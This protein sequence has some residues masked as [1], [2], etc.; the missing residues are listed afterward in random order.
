MS[1]KC[2][3]LQLRLR[4]ALFRHYWYLGALKALLIV[5]IF[6]NS[7]C[8]IET[9]TKV[10]ITNTNPLTFKLRGDGYLSRFAIYGPLQGNTNKKEPPLIWELFPSRESS[11]II[12]SRIS[13]VKYGEAPPGWTQHTPDN[14]PQPELKG[15]LAYRA[16]ANTNSANTGYI[17]FIVRGGKVI[18]LPNNN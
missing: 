14:L 7:G 11:Q 3:S 5:M 12:V 15:G 9:D 16:T 2:Y 10:S 8:S 4:K 13:P 6:I 18:I 17:D 1:D